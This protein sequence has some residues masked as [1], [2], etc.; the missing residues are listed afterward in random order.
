MGVSSDNLNKQQ[1]VTGISLKCFESFMKFI[2]TGEYKHFDLNDSIELS[3]Q[4]NGIEFYFG[5]NENQNEQVKHLIELIDLNL[6]EINEN[7]FKNLLNEIKNEDDERKRNKS[8]QYIS[9]NPHLMKS[10]SQN[11]NQK[12]QN[13]VRD[14]LLFHS[15]QNNNK[16]E[17]INNQQNQITKQLKRETEQLRKENKVQ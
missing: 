3:N 11:F 13:K 12:D 1:H 9:Q 6:K 14:T 10:I 5:S 17:Q 15:I 8:I 4:K 7:C 16:L 2:Y